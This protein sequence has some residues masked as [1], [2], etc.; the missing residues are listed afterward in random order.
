MEKTKKGKYKQCGPL[1]ECELNRLDTY[2]DVV[3]KIAKFLGIACSSSCLYRPHGGA[4]IPAQE[5]SIDGGEPVMWTLGIYMRMKHAGPE[6]IQLGVD[7]SN[8]SEEESDEAIQQVS[9]S[10]I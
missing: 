1:I 10:S 5:I 6:V 7:C 2:T 4:I 8:D 3:E 9:N